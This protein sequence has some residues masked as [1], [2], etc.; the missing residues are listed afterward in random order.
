M[1]MGLHGMDGPKQKL[2]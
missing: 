1:D 2:K